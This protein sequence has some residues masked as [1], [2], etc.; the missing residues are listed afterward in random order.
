MPTIPVRTMTDSE[1]ITVRGTFEQCIEQLRPYTILTSAEL[2]AKRREHPDLRLRE[3]WTANFAMYTIED[4]LPCLYFGGRQVN[5]LL[6]EGS[7]LT[8][9]S[10]D[11]DFVPSP[12]QVAAIKESAA[13]GETFKTSLAELRHF[14]PYALDYV[15]ELTPETLAA[16]TDAEKALLYRIY[17]E[18]FDIDQLR[19]MTS[20][21]G[22]DHP[23][24]HTDIYIYSPNYIR[25]RL[26]N[27]DV[28]IKSC[29]IWGVNFETDTFL[30]LACNFDHISPM[31][32]IRE[33]Y[34]N[35]DM[36]YNRLLTQSDILEYLD[37]H[38]LNDDDFASRL[39]DAVN[40]Y[41]RRDR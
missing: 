40:K 30:N 21:Q 26:S 5:P 34:R 11:G 7:D 6:A 36:D 24:D 18:G 15:L 13:R 4:G 27:I 33:E 3:S 39:L 31:T 41:L 29:M 9:M 12:H 1:L 32:A 20:Q 2:I 16:C 17:G 38:P 25:R 28:I 23:L 14:K 10:L 19:D 8:R 22:S 35:S 37:S